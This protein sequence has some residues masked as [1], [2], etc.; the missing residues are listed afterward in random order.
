MGIIDPVGFGG[1][2][3]T[4]VLEYGNAPIIW[5][6]TLGLL[7]TAAAAIAAS[8]WHPRR[9]ARWTGVGQRRHAVLRVMSRTT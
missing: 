3:M 6:L 1:M 8:V 7:A 5:A 2:A 4:V 9:P